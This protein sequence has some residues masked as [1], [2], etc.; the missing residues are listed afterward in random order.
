MRFLRRIAGFLGFAKDE[1]HELKDEGDYDAGANSAEHHLHRKG[2]SVPVQVPVERPQQ[3]PVL[4]PCGVGEGGVQV[5]LL[6]FLS[7]FMGSIIDRFDFVR[8]C[9][10]LSSKYLLV[11]GWKKPNRA[12]NE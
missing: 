10:N 6:Y 2:V 4:V 7:I 9:V 11:N 3:G 1:E 12:T 8:H 5:D